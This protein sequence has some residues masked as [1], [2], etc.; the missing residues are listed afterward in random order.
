MKLIIFDL[1]G[2]LINSLP[3]MKFALKNTADHIK[4][5]ISFNSYKSSKKNLIYLSKI[6]NDAYKKMFKR[7]ERN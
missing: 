4:Q 6:H 7:L 5:K 3:N 1:D 2:V